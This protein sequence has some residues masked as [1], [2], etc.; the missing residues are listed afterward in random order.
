VVRKN[1]FAAYA[2]ELADKLE[3]F[4]ADFYNTYVHLESSHFWFQARGKLIIWAL[5]KYVP[6]MHSFLEIG[7]GTGFILSRVAVAFPRARLIGSEMFSTALKFASLRLP[8]VE[9]AQIDARQI[10][11]I[12]EFEV[13]GAFDVIEHVEEDIEVLQQMYRALKSGGVVFLTIPQHQWLWSQVDEYSCHVRRY[14]AAELHGKL[15]SVGFVVVRSTSFVSLLLP[16][17]MISRGVKKRKRGNQSETAELVV[18]KVLNVVFSFVMWLEAIFIKV[19][20]NF[21]IGASRLVVA[22]K[23]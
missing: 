1:G 9:F 8:S 18:P 23:K 11:Y 2:P 14:E 4:K 17:M 15:I 13:I 3:G 20:V 19:G 7:C 10:P 21:P 6:R 16:A 5:K 22:R 12:D